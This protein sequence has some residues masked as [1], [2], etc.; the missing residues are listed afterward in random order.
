VGRYNTRMDVLD[1]LLGGA[2]RVRLLRLFL[3]NP[4]TSFEAKD[5]SRRIKVKPAFV[6]K[7]LGTLALAKFIKKG[8]KG[9][10]LSRS[11]E[12]LAPLRSLLLTSD[13]FKD[14]EIVRRF[15]SG[16][17]M[18]VV[19]VAGVFTQSSDSRVDILLVGDRLKRSTIEKAL[20]DMEA[21]VGKEL[22]YALFDTPEFKYRMEVFDKFIR[23]ILDY[24]H[25][26]LLDKI[27]I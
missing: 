17:N 10:K 27:G 25:R 23:D 24:P 15:K 18:K 2:S 6:R 22:S 4:D 7:E 9:Y 5:V 11:F 13:P 21:E 1:K 20:K 16:G 12:F 19:A 8:A 3:L 26:V 14:E